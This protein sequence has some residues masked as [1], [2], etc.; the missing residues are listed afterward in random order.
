MHI[1]RTGEYK[2]NRVSQKELPHHSRA[3]SDEQNAFI[4]KWVGFRQFTDIKEKY[5]TT[6]IKYKLNKNKMAA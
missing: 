2:N 5:K 1:Y 6:V 4:E 3:F